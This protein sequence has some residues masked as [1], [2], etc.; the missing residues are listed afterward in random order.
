MTLT[1]TFFNFK[2][3][4]CVHSIVFFVAQYV[5]DLGEFGIFVYFVNECHLVFCFLGIFFFFSGGAWLLA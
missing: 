1:F 5:V 2:G 3:I 4:E